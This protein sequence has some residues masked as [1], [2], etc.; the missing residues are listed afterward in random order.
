MGGHIKEK[1]KIWC[2][3]NLELETMEA[4]PLPPSSRQYWGKEKVTKHLKSWNSGNEGKDNDEMGTLF[5]G[6]RIQSVQRDKWGIASQ[7]S[8]YVLQSPSSSP[9]SQPH[10]EARR[11]GSPF[12]A[13]HTH[14]P[15]ETQSRSRMVENT[16]EW[17]QTKCIK[18][19]KVII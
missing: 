16:S 1:P 12:D 14:Q 11:L 15:P 8:L 6:G 19:R 2:R 17:G 9:V 10:P 13:A 18:D 3:D 5:L 4:S 7:N